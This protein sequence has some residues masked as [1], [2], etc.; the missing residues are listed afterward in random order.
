MNYFQLKMKR[1]ILV[2]PVLLAPVYSAWVD[3]YCNGYKVT[4]QSPYSDEV[5]DDQFSDKYEQYTDISDSET[6]DYYV[7]DVRNYQKSGCYY[8][9]STNL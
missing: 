6:M 8:F 2:L 7:L 4:N 9:E 1:L 3:K 5:Y